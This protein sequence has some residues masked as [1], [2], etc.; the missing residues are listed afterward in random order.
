M[1]RAVEITEANGLVV[2]R[3]PVPGDMR[4]DG[5]AWT[6]WN[7][8]RWSRAVYSLHPGRLRTQRGL[9]PHNRVDEEACRRALRTAVER[10]VATGRA[11]VALERPTAAILGYRRPVSHLGH[12]ILTLLTGGLWLLV[13]VVMVLRREEDRLR[14]LSDEWGHVWAE[15]ADF[16]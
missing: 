10:E 16:R 4:W 8:R 14:L 11:T 13:W 7:G 9:E 5:D 3:K 12:A 15:P 1:P 6:R 2:R